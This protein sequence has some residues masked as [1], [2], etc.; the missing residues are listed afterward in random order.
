MQ[1]MI[2]KILIA[3]LLLSSFALISLANDSDTTSP[4]IF[5]HQFHVIE[6]EVE[7]DA[8]HIDISESS[9]ASDRNLPTMDECSSCHDVEDDEE[10]GMC[11]RV[12]DEPEAPVDVE[13]GV[14]FDHAGHL[15]RDLQCDK[16]HT[17]ISQS[18]T[19]G[20]H[21]F[22]AMVVCMSCHDG[23]QASKDCNL[24]HGN[25]VTLADLHP[26]GW[27]NDHSSK[28]IGDQKYCY[29]CHTRESFCIN[30]HQGDNLTGQAHDLNFEFTHGL[31]AKGKTFD[32]AG[33]H[34][35]TL[36]CNDC[37]LRENRMPL[38]HSTAA[39]SIRHGEA[40]RN[41]IENCAAC[42]D[43]ADPTCARIGCHTDFDGQIN[44]QDNPIHDP[45][46]SVFDS[47]GSWHEERSSFCFGCHTD[48]RQAGEGFCGYCH[49]DED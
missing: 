29:G 40:A 25:D 10:C 41:D 14:S 17:K 32:C 44:G 26:T 19:T 4:L 13:R 5:S 7:C 28:A 3:G 15:N 27:N 49:G 18:E 22:P 38:E 33:C 31:Q 35:L 30:C 2:Y 21:N 9:D 11:H 34:D 20:D 42:H 39:W 6:Q 43:A 24:C 16:C 47:E 46:P 37:H 1:R 45:D 36:F 48:T 8:C 12:A 23:S